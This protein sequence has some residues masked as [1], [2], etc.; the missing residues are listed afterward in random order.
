MTLN[1]FLKKQSFCKS[2][3]ALTNSLVK[4]FFEQLC[5][6]LGDNC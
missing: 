2:I 1:D 3:V 5:P 6:Q 4:L